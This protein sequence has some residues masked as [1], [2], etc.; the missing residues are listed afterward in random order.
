MLAG[1]DGLDPRQINVKTAAYTKALTGD[2]SGLRIG[3]VKEG[4]GHAVSEAVVDALV[5]KGAER[6][7]ELGAT[8][9][10]VSDPHAP[11]G[12]CHLDADRRRG[13]A[14]GR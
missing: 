10:E 12:A 13:R 11:R 6:F 2:A 9:E 8:V 14:P 3:V 7:K 1:P 4:F 5:R